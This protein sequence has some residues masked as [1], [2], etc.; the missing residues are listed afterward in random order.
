MKRAVDRERRER[1]TKSVK[2]LVELLGKVVFKPAEHQ[3][4]GA[5]IAA[6]SSQ[7]ALAQFE[8]AELGIFP[9][10]LNTQKRVAQES[11][12]YDA[13]D[14]LRRNAAD[15]LAEERTRKGKSNKTT[16]AG[17]ALRVKELEKEVELLEA[18]L[19]QTTHALSRMIL[20]G[21][22]LAEAVGTPEALARWR[23]ELRSIELGLSLRKKP[24]PASNVLPFATGRAAD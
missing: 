16:K 14:R 20:V 15:S 22:S 4:N 5:L 3:E 18:D 7:G 13:L 6:V 23:K 19:G 2:A 24:L 10:S 21:K 1:D 17:L 11:S 9:M 8:N 12:G